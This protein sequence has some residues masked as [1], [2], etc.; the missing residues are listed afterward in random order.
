MV[1]ITEA[2]KLVVP[3]SAVWAELADFHA[4]S[5]WA[6]NV[7]HSCLTNSTTSG[8]GMTRRIQTG[9]TTV[10]ETVID[11]EPGCQLAYSIIG[12]PPVIRSVTNTWRLAQLGDTTEVRVTSTIDAGSRPPQKLVAVVV[13][14]ALAKASRQMLEGLDRHL[15]AE[16]HQGV[17][18]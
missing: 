12:L 10:L 16:Q 8:V 6:P 7:D 15:N 1:S 9:R 2:R 18:A 5:R 14:R 4:I 11:W 13:G 3:A 17:S